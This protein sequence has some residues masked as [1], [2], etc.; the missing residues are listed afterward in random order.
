MPNPADSAWVGRQIDTRYVIESELGGGGMGVVLRGRHRF[1]GAAVAIKMMRA[2]LQIDAGLQE[3]FLAEARAPAMIGHPAIVSVTDAG[4][5]QS[6]ELYLVMELLQ[7]DPLRAFVGNGKLKRPDIRRVGAEL[8]D[9]LGAAHAKGFVHRDL[10]PENVFL[11]G[12]T[13]IV[14][15]LDFGIAKTLAPDL[16]SP[17]TAAGVV[18]GTLLYMSPEQLRDPRSVDGRSD[19]WS[20]GVILYELLSG[21]LPYRGSTGAELYTALATKEPE[22]IARTMPGVGPEISAF[23]AR[24]LSRDPKGRFTS[25]AEMT[26]ALNALPLAAGTAVGQAPS[27]T[28][29]VGATQ[30]TLA[31]ADPARAPAEAMIAAT[32]PPTGVN[33]P[34]GAIGTWPQSPPLATPPPVA[35]P[36]TPVPATPVAPP[37]TPRPVSP[38][39]PV[40]LGATPPVIA[41]T[42]VSPLVKQRT[43]TRYL[44]Y[45]LFV[46]ALGL[47]I[48]ALAVG[49]RGGHSST[50]TAVDKPA[51]PHPVGEGAVAVAVAPVVDAGDA[52]P[53]DSAVTTKPPVD[54][55]PVDKPP[56]DKPPVKPPVDKPVD[57]PP[58][59]K[60]PVDKP[61]I[62]KPVDKPPVTNPSTNPP[63]TGPASALHNACV[64]ACQEARTCALEPPKCVESCEANPN[65]SA[66][67]RAATN[68]NAVASCAFRLSCP[69]TPRGTAS[70]AQTMNCQDS[71]RGDASCICQCI[72]PMSPIHTYA[73]WQLD[74]CAL[75]C[76]GGLDHACIN[77]R[78]ANVVNQCAR[79]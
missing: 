12:P 11:E 54:K 57:K 64:A 24:A 32:M 14:R 7:G 78:C 77:T 21:A 8:L 50:A 26:A 5:M 16:A 37:T 71:C 22:P 18:L 58:V 72:G 31:G 30:W 53:P 1:T 68:C 76:S 55:P 60:P 27:P 29:G 40:P 79:Q 66:C 61:P 48:A 39:T 49:L 17:K 74:A 38:T 44:A 43:N 41:P 73:L 9:A 56:V 69:S 42:V 36:A 15:L 2:D 45:A 67:G 51:T 70:C 46:L 33:P 23:F 10:K 62:D 6:G 75:T 19:L 65:A 20:V 47:I 52:A 4:K 13:R 3:R 35:A 63:Q 25:A 28:I 59:A 34:V